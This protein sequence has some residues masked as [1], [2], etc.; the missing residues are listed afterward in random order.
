MDYK[1][2]FQR[3]IPAS[4]WRRAI[5]YI[6]DVLLVATVVTYPLQSLFDNIPQQSFTALFS[7]LQN[8]SDLAYRM[9]AV[10]LATA[11]FSILYWTILEYKLRQ[12]VGKLLLNISVASSTKQ[13]TFFQCFVRNIP[14]FSNILLLLDC[15]FMFFKGGNQRFFETLSHTEV[16]RGGYNGK[17]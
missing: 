2:F 14:K 7:Y 17:T 3:S 5:A 4:L 6:I 11:L 9:A 10:F 16:I 1:K 12:S 8:H 13:F 15:S